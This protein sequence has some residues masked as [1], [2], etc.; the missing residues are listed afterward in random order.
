MLSNA[1]FS[2]GEKNTR[3]GGWI[4]LAFSSPKIEFN[5]HSLIEFRVWCN[6]QSLNAAD[7]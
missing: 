1:Q 2:E 6:V 7:K 5:D 4:V 3:K